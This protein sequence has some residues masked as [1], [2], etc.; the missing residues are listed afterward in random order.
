MVEQL[1]EEQI[2]EFKEAFS[3]FDKD[4]DG[5]I[6]ASELGTVMR[7][8]GTSPT[9]AEVKEILSEMGKSANANIDFPEFLTIMARKLENNGTEEDVIAAFKVFDKDGAGTVSAA[10]IRH[11]ITNIGETLSPEEADAMLKD[12]E[13]DGSGRINYYKFAK[14]LMSV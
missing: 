12:A 6:K 13:I 10:E 4:S 14:T 5:K 9:N 11:V 2:A 8:L 7:S 1:S 3:L